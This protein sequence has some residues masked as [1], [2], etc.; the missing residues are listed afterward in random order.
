MNPPEGTPPDTASIRWTG[1]RARVRRG[2]VAAAAACAATL[3]LPPSGGAAPM[4]PSPG[5]LAAAHEAWDNRASCFECHSP[6]ETL[7]Q[8]CLACHSEIAW[9]REKHRGLHARVAAIECATCHRDHAGRNAAMIRWDEGAPERFRHA[10][11]GW[12]LTGAHAR[13]ACRSCHSIENQR[14][15]VGSQKLDRRTSW[16]GLDASCASCHA[17]PHGGRFGAGCDRCHRTTAWREIARAGFDHDKTRF[18]LRGR[19]AALA[20]ASCHDAKKAWGPKPAFSACRDCH[21]DAHAG[22]ATL[23]G[24]R[25]DCAA[26]HDVNGFSSSTFTAKRHARTA[27]A[28]T[29]RHAAVACGGCHVRES[30]AEARRLGPARVR[31]R[32]RFDRCDRCHEDAH[33]GQLA[34]SSRSGPE[35]GVALSVVTGACSG[36]HVTA[37]WKPSSFGARDHA[38]LRFVLQGAH[39]TVDCRGCHGVDRPGLPPP[40]GSARAGPA[41]FVFRITEVGCVDCH[42]DPHGRRFSAP[43][44]LSAG[45]SG[46][47]GFDSFRPATYDVERHA[48]SPFPLEGAHRAV[49]CDACHRELRRE[50]GGPALLRS[51]AQPTPMSLRIE[52]H[53]CADCHED[54]HGT[55]FRGRK[56][57]GACD[58]CHGDDAFRPASRFDHERDA[59]FPLRGAHARVACER[60]HREERDR[61]GRSVVTYRGV[62]R[63]CEDCHAA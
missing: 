42:V 46:C 47:H 12:L 22:T 10:R 63:R 24:K 38:A 36:C 25:V 61:S 18:A 34:E 53:A 27:Y 20:C 52:R 6:G 17:D 56:G 9:Y 39:A 60:C 50:P 16:L 7:S 40:A 30:G 33:A 21:G 4:K 32:P 3:L 5:P 15:S 51:A 49:R 54:P 13:V 41:R 11:T 14:A 57:G 2:A 48:R 37:G 45:C 43:N 26:C 8:R 44:A 1:P 58:S 62:S 35:P 59:S 28:L 29:G 55:Q 19:H 31:M 23:A